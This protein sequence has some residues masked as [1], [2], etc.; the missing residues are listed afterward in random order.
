MALSPKIMKLI[1]T[2]IQNDAQLTHENPLLIDKIIRIASQH[3]LRIDIQY[4]PTRQILLEELPKYRLSLLEEL[5]NHA[6]TIYQKIEHAH[7]THSNTNLYATRGKFNSEHI[8]QRRERDWLQDHDINYLMPRSTT[9]IA[10]VASLD[11]GI[12]NSQAFSEGI[13]L[14]LLNPE[15][16]H[17]MFP[18]GPSHWRGGYLSKPT[19]STPYFTLEIFDSFGANSA[20]NVLNFVLNALKMCGIDASNLSVKFSSPEVLQRDGYSCGDFVCAHSHQKMLDFG[21]PRSAVN[22]ELVSALAQ[23]NTQHQL[24]KTMCKQFELTP[25]AQRSSHQQHIQDILR[26]KNTLFK[27]AQMIKEKQKNYMPITNE[28]YATLL[29]VEEIKKLKRK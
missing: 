12:D 28:E 29:Q 21:A 14:Q 15:V 27:N 4:R 24:R 16:Q 11:T 2:E 13:Q 1:K 18:I 6:L 9:N 7:H 26:I 8:H 17:I 20:K 19:E 10:V 23:G 3:D 5:D 25:I 22:I